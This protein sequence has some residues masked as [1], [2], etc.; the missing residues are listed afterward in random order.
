ML[1][2]RTLALILCLSI[3]VSWSVQQS[4]AERPFTPSTTTPRPTF[5]P[6]KSQNSLLSCDL[7]N[8]SSGLLGC[9]LSFS[10]DYLPAF[11]TTAVSNATCTNNLADSTYPC[12]NIHLQSY[13]PMAE[14]GG[15][16]GNDMWGWT[17]PLTSKEYVIMGR[18]T[19]TS[20]IDI[21]DPTN[22]IYLG[23]LP[24]A[25]PAQHWRDMK[26][27]D[28]H[29][30][31]VADAATSHGMQVFDL[32]QLRSVSSPPVTFA[33]TVRYTDLGSAHNIF[34]NEDSGTGYA[35]G[36]SNTP[37]R[38]S[39]GLHMIDIQTPTSPT[40]LGCYDQDGYIHDTQCVIYTGPDTE[41][42]GKEL[43]FNSAV[44]AFTIVDVTDKSTPMR[45][46]SE[47]Y[48]S[49]V[50]AHQGW[51][52]AD[53]RYYLLNDEGDESSTDQHAKTY[54]WDVSDLDN[55]QLVN[56][57]TAVTPAIDH[58][59]YIKNGLVF[60]A[61]YRSGLRVLHFSQ[62]GL[63]TLTE[64][65]YFDTFPTFTTNEAKYNGAWSVYPYFPSGS[66]AVSTIEH[67]LFVL[68]LDDSITDGNYIP[69]QA[70]EFLP[71]ILTE[72]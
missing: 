17:D 66:V 33:E 34:I 72:E 30:Y 26:V 3:F 4:S 48:V 51:L 40:F 36:L 22:P 67:G 69:T 53:Q 12:D 24:S 8:K 27:Y 46:A 5:T 50:Y 2:F 9:H 7:A 55:P 38:C 62:V 47:E 19:G 58:N 18:T 65:G 35:L 42:S 68:K 70:F 10:R 37:N 14:M 61:N 29:A 11:D 28:N 20:F 39:G 1:R 54:I 16:N 13:L 45:L 23:D 32:T 56:V 6:T 21:S 71:L 15:G 43:C 25:T 31:I 59:L 63:P 57:Y 64:I 49:S 60:E 44:D 41:Y 52:T